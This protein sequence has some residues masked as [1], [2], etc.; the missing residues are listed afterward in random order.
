MRILL[1]SHGYPPERVGGTETYTMNLAR[2]L[3][4]SDKVAVFTRT[5]S[6]GVDF[7]LVKRMDGI[8]EVTAVR[9]NYVS[10]NQYDAHYNNPY[11]DKIFG[12]FLDDFQPDVV[13]FTYFLGGLS[14]GCLLESASRKIRTVCTLTDFHPICAWGQL[15]THDGKECEGPDEGVRCASC[16]CG[17]EPYRGV[18]WWRRVWLKSKSAKDKVN[19]LTS[20]GFQRMRKRLDYIRQMLLKA[21][22]IISPTIFLKEVYEKNGV[23][24]S[25]LPFAIDSKIFAGFQRKEADIFRIAFIGTLL[26]LKG[27]HILVEALGKIGDDVPPWILKVYGD[28]KGEKEKKYLDEVMRRASDRVKFCGTFETQ[29]IKEIYEDIDL[30]VIPSLWAENSP[31]VLLF[32]LHTATPVVSADIRGV[33]DVAGEDGAFYYPSMNVKNLT[34]TLKKI[35]MDKNVLQRLKKVK[36]QSM[37]EHIVELKRLYGGGES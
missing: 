11:I 3:S 5:H 20:P 7:E 30:L 14:A 9:N 16:F 22:V 6:E 34:K 28:E 32:A 15:L 18:S 10:F 33:K 35:L 17:E 23:T 1:V 13:H 8:I 21:D 31:M 36:V 25:H 29:K 24:S 26:P 27:L 2:A 12:R 37:E 4:A 19:Y